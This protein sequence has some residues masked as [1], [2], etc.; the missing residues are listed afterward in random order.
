MNN[1]ESIQRFLN[2]NQSKDNR[3]GCVMLFADVPD[4]DKLTHRI[5]KED[6]VYDPADEPG[7]Y[8]YEEKPHITII[9]G[10]HHDE[11]LDESTI[12][13]RIQDK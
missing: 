13:K 8:G 11:I 4:W 1:F 6:D 7:E 9:Y 5:V 10:L 3:Y 12:H 2:E